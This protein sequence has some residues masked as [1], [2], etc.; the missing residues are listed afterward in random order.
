[1][2][3]LPLVTQTGFVHTEPVGGHAPQSPGQ[4][5]QVSPASHVPLPHVLGQVPQS[6]VAAL[7]TFPF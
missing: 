5:E 4:L 1:M 3:L 7:K 6:T 2:S